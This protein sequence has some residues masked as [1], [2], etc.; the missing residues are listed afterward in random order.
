MAKSK[1]KQTP[2]SP[3]PPMRDDQAGFYFDD[4]DFAPH[5]PMFPG[6][7]MVTLRRIDHSANDNMD[8]DELALLNLLKNL[9]D[10]PEP[11]M[12]HFSNEH[13]N[14]KVNIPQ[15][16]YDTMYKP[17]TD[18]IEEAVPA[19]ADQPQAIGF[20]A[21]A[22]GILMAP[23]PLSLKMMAWNLITEE[24]LSTD[25]E[26]NVGRGVGFKSTD[27]GYEDDYIILPPCQLFEKAEEGRL[28][29]GNNTEI[30]RFGVTRLVKRLDDE[31]AQQQPVQSG[32][33]SVRLV[34]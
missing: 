1:K 28:F 3:E 2:Q 26:V 30:T 22:D 29:D 8:T 23:L 4:E 31:L 19:V 21:S 15:F 10:A 32:V 34:R 16:E 18:M 5:M 33:A 24:A 17:M 11:D 20:A 12:R 7:F 27:P 14:I 9:F 25:D 13:Y 6:S